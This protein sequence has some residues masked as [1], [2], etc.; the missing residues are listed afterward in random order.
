MFTLRS[1]YKYLVYLGLWTGIT[2]LICFGCGAD[3]MT[4]GVGGGLLVVLAYILGPTM[5]YDVRSIPFDDTTV[6]IP[7]WVYGTVLV[8]SIVAMLVY[9]VYFGNPNNANSMAI[10]PFDSTVPSWMSVTTYSGELVNRYN[11]L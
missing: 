11:I 4:F 6:N 9:S 5:K 2:A 7:D 3:W 1:V 10:I 8:V